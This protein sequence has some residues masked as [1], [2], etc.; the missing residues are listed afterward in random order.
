MKIAQ[1]KKELDRLDRVALTL[2]KATVE[3]RKSIKLVMES[4]DEKSREACKKLTDDEFMREY[5][6]EEGKPH[7]IIDGVLKNFTGNKIL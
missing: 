5:G 7:P 6:K 4:V 2:G 3:L 1:M